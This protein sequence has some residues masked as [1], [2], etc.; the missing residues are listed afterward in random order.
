M[1]TPNE[2]YSNIS[3]CFSELKISDP[4]NKQETIQE[5]IKDNKQF[6]VNFSKNNHII[7][8]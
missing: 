5:S 2:N 6:M 1:S 4:K 7:T 8:N 3:N